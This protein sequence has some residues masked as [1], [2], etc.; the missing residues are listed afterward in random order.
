V[1]TPVSCCGVGGAVSA[2]LAPEPHPASPS[3][4]AHSISCWVPIGFVLVVQAASCPS[5]PRVARED[6]TEPC[7]DPQ[8]LSICRNAKRVDL[9]PY[10]PFPAFATRIN[11][12]LPPPVVQSSPPNSL[13][14]YTLRDALGSTATVLT[15]LWSGSDGGE[16]REPVPGSAAIYAAIEAAAFSLVQRLRGRQIDDVGVTRPYRDV[17]DGKATGQTSPRSPLIRTSVEGVRRGKEDIASPKG[18][19]EMA[20]SV[21]G[22]LAP[23]PIRAPLPTKSRRFLV[24]T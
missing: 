17:I 7:P 12:Q 3:A 6:A 24:V 21:R 1:V 14:T 2:C 15:P 13:P 19:N 23:T 20:R 4:A 9:G 18:G 16:V 11:R 5:N 8:R 22:S 10:V